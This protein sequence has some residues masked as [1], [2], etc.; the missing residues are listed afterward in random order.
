ML[1]SFVHNLADFKVL[2]VALLY[3]HTAGLPQRQEKPRKIGVFENSQEKL[4]SLTKFKET[5]DFSV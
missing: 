2:V 5:S 4:G 1:K 3:M